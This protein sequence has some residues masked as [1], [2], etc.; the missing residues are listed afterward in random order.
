MDDIHR[1]NPVGA[2][3]ESRCNRAGFQLSPSF[4]HAKYEISHPTSTMNL[5]NPNYVTLT[6]VGNCF[7]H[8]LNR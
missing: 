8:L 2:S 5:V 6:D 7:Y 4:V 3:Q 1:R